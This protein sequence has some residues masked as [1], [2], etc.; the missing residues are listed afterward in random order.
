M[1]GIFEQF[2]Y[3]N[4]HDLNLDWVLKTI[5]E[6]VAEIIKFGE[7]ID[8]FP[9]IYE[10][11]D[12]ITN[13]RKL[14]PIGNF[15]GTLDGRKANLVNAGI[16]NNRQQIQYIAEQFLDGQTGQVVDGGFFT[17]DGIRKNYNGGMF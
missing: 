15:T 13:K 17:E 12:N 7:T 4:F 14:S 3:T 8:I 16:D 10:T 6:C 2:P 5:K 9:T 11:K 1:K